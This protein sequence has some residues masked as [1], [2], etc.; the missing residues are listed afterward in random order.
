MNS[1]I[2]TV[3]PIGKEAHTQTDKHLQ[4]TREANRINKSSQNGLSF[5]YLKGKQQLHQFLLVYYILV[6][7]QNKPGCINGTAIQVIIL[8]MT[9]YIHEKPQQKC[10]LG[11]TVSNGLLGGGGSNMLYRI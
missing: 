5:N 3:N 4:K 10:S 6:M 9:I 7:K 8:L 1:H 2:P 11:G